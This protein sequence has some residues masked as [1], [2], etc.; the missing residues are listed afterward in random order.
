ML[1]AADVGR[2]GY[3]SVAELESDNALKQ[4]IEALRLEAGPLMNL[5]DVVNRTVPKMCLLAPPRSGGVICTRTFIPQRVHQAIGV[6][7]A[8]SVAAACG[9]EDSA[10]SPLLKDQPGPGRMV[11]EHPTGSFTVEIEVV[12]ERETYAVK[13]SALLRT[14]RKLMQGTVFVTADP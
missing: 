2:T 9:I 6:L 1:R 7:G 11:I 8:A 5:G 3:E 4:A 14:A 10:A 12:R 13:R